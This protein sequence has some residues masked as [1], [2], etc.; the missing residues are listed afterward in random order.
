VL[1]LQRELAETKDK[2]KIV[3]QK[4]ANVRKERDQLKQE[5]KEL[6]D[7]VLSLQSSIR[8]MVPCSSNTSSAFPMMNELQNL[9][10][11]F[12]KCDCQ[13]VF[14]DLLC[15]E[16]NLDGVVFFFQNTFPTV[17]EVVEKYFSPVEQ[18]LKKVTSTSLLD[19]PVITVLRKTYQQNW[20]QIHQ[21][22]LPAQANDQIMQKVQAVLSIG[23]E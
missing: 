4:F 8:N 3:T 5:N 18:V 2:L 16:L 1:E 21:Q 17:V 14:F 20:K 12:Y 19:G 6:Q 7:E 13:D 9:A 22:C 15:P 23:D 10:S 11:E